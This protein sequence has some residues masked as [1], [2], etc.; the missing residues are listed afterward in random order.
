MKCTHLVTNG[1]VV[2][3]VKTLCAINMGCVVV[4]LDWVK[5]CL[6]AGAV[7]DPG[8]FLVADKKAETTYGFSLQESLA[9]ARQRKIFAGLD[10]ALTDNVKPPPQ[11]LTV[12]RIV[13]WAGAR[14][15]R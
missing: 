3:T 5:Q 13:F 1:A 8:R 11:K 2:R 12:T 14:R 6:A 9:R 7:V 4:T 10:F 15:S